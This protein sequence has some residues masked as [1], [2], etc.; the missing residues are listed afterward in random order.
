MYYVGTR[1][2]GQASTTV[3]INAGTYTVV[4]IFTSTNSNYGSTKS[5]P[6]TFTIHARANW[7]GHS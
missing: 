3:P 7:S 1:T 2:S 6:V 4:A 5:A